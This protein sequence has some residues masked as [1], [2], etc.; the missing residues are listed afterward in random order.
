MAAAG[1]AVGM[2]VL[3]PIVNESSR[4]VFVGA[5]Q[6]SLF[7]FVAPSLLVLGAP[8]PAAW[9]VGWLARLADRRSRNP[10]P[11]HSVAVFLVSEAIVLFWRLPYA[12]DALVRH[13]LLVMV[14]L[15]T[16]L[17]AGIALWL[18]LLNSPPLV[19]RLPRQRR[20]VVATLAMWAIWAAAYL[21]GLSHT[22]S[23]PAY[24][25]AR[26]HG[27]TLSADQ[28]V[29]A[30]VL[31]T[32]PAFAFLPVIFANLMGWLREEQEPDEELREM[33]RV[34]RR[35]MRWESGSELRRD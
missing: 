2:G 26:V 9:R 8:W 23:Y 4:Y 24:A 15:V 31:W 16:L 33:T 32:I 30:V 12:V 25:T 21:V 7:A 18:E 3:P 29:M 35:R 28:Q 13:P 5:I 34:E 19:P 17:F 22:A 1:L 11:S 10:S 27:L 20:M 14:E 6:F